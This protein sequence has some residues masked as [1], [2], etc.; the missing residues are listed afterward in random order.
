MG[1]TGA[2]AIGAAAGIIC[3]FAVT[4]FKAV[5][6]I[7]DTLDVFAL[8]G[9]GGLVGTVMTPIFASTDI[10]PITATVATN[11]LGACVVMIYAGVM[12]W[13]ILMVIKPI[14]GLR[15]EPD[16]EIIGLDVSQHGEMLSGN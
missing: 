6:K 9:V 12:T 7:D 14:A 8:H 1:I 2:L 3:F 11:V 4:N 16:A 13:V 10:A 5:T 15:V